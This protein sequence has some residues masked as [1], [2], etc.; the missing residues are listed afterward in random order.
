MKAINNRGISKLK[1]ELP[2]EALGDFNQA[3]GIDPEYELIYKNRGISKALLGDM[4][5]ACNDW[6]R[7][8]ELGVELLEEWGSFCQ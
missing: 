3:A 8:E 4:D 7:A 1:L 5:G 6:D 2:E